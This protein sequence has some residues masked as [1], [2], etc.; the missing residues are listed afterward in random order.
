MCFQSISVSNLSLRIQYS[1]KSFD[2]CLSFFFPFFFYIL[3]FEKYIQF[4]LFK[5]NREEYFIYRVK[6]MYNNKDKNK[7]KENYIFR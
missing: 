7:L 2:I 3:L 5:H 4:K 1:R 6:A